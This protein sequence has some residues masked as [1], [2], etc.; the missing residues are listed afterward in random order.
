MRAIDLSSR[1]RRQAA[2]LK[3]DVSGSLLLF[4]MGD[5]HYYALNAVGARVW[6]LCDGARSVSD[7]IAILSAEFD[8]PA[9]TI[10][11]DIL[12]LLHELC[13]ERLVVE[14]DSAT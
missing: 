2:I 6:D 8:A 7:V 11:Q 1:F 13:D 4:D 10:D 14:A 5:G 9:A 12:D 3:Q